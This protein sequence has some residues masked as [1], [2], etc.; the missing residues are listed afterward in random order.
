MR[1]MDNRDLLNSDD[2]TYAF[3]YTVKKLLRILPYASI[4]IIMYYVTVIYVE[5]Y[6]VYHAMY[7]VLQMPLELL[8]L[9]MTG[10]TGITLNFPVWY[11]SSLMIALPLVMYCY[12]INKDFFTSYM[13]TII[14]MLIYGWMNNT[15]HTIGVWHEWTGIVH[16]AVIRAFADL[17]LGCLIFKLSEKLNNL[18]IN[19]FGRIVLTFLEVGGFIAVCIV[20]IKPRGGYS[21]QCAVY[22]MIISLSITFSRKSWTYRLKGKILSDFCRALG[23]LSIPVYCIH[24]SV[25]KIVEHYFSMQSY[26]INV[27]YTFM[28]LFLMSYAIEILVDKIIPNSFREKHYHDNKC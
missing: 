3:R 22:L 26:L 16:A 12:F 19:A 25:L 23:K 7:L 17:L 10:A 1:N 15:Y 24:A 8:Q 14:P 20:A 2:A 18:K 21:F 27:L 5:H 11:L 9:S 13:I 6:D 28:L 4:G